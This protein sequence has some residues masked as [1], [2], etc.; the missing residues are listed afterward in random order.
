MNVAWWV[1]RVDECSTKKMT[2]RIFVG[3]RLT[4]QSQRANSY[5]SKRV[6]RNVLIVAPQMIM[7]GHGIC[8]S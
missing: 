7:C 1:C 5:I 4:I 2:P 6:V 3:V 8:S